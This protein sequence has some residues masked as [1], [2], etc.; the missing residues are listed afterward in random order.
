MWEKLILLQYKSPKLIKEQNL[1]KSIRKAKEFLLKPHWMTEGA[2]TVLICSYEK[3]MLMA[4]SSRKSHSCLT[5]WLL[6]YVNFSVSALYMMIALFLHTV[7]QSA[8]LSWNTQDIYCFSTSHDTST[9]TPFPPLSL[10]SP[11]PSLPVYDP[12][13]TYGT[14]SYYVAPGWPGILCWPGWLWNLN[15]C[16]FLPWDCWDWRSVPPCLTEF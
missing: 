12:P 11:S 10:P 1:H 4:T 13:H 3:M 16:L 6:N 5:W 8:G 9:T 14:G 2:V 7:L 15:I